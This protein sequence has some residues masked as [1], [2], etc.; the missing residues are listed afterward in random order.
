M[1]GPSSLESFAEIVWRLLAL[2]GPRPPLEPLALGWLLWRILAFA[3]AEHGL[4]IT[5]P[6]RSWPRILFWWL[7]LFGL[8]DGAFRNGPKVGP[9]PAPEARPTRLE[10]AP[11]A[12]QGLERDHE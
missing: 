8:A 2:F 6:W 7:V 1:N 11:P 12:V 3:H 9:V 4:V 5:P 10:A